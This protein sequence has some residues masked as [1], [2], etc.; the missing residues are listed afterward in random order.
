MG[1]RKRTGTPYT[2]ALKA[3]G[4][5]DIEGSVC[6]TATP[7]FA[8]PPSSMYCPFSYFPLL[9]KGLDVGIGSKWV[10]IGDDFTED[11][12]AAK[13]DLKLRTIWYNTA[14]RKAKNE[15]EEQARRKAKSLD[16]GEEEKKKAADGVGTPSA[17]QRYFQ[18][19]A[20]IQVSQ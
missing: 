19:R 11:I 16:E 3:A 20:A 8:P 14:E 13:A 4:K 15:E 17:N 2:A 6:M 12:V 1:A 18:D 5:S 9:M 7:L 10:H